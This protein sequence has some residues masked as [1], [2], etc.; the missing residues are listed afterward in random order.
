MEGQQKI[1]ISGDSFGEL[2]AAILDKN[3]K[4]AQAILDALP[5]EGTAN[6]WSEEIYFTIPV[7]SD[8]EKG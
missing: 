5:F 2:E 6:V 7:D 8:E 3:E 4:T 1:V